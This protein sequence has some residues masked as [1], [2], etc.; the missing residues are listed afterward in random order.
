MDVYIIVYFVHAIFRVSWNF[1]SIAV[2]DD[3]ANDGWWDL[4]DKT[5]ILIGALNGKGP[6]KMPKA[7]NTGGPSFGQR[8]RG[9]VESLN[10]PAAEMAAVVVSGGIT[11]ALGGKTNKYIDKA[12]LLRG[13]KCPRVIFHLVI[14]YLCKADLESAS[15][16]VQQFISLLP[17]L[18]TSDDDQSKNRL[19]FYI[20]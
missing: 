17:L 19:H 14:L 8:A 3:K 15:R 12:M 20:W 16:C 10:I 5:W 6:S 13:E 18:L 7:S 4:Y 11:N 2:E 9:L 1:K